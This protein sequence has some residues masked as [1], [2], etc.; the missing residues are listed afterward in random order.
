MDFMVN[1]PTTTK[2]HDVVIIIVD[3]LTKRAHFWPTLTRAATQDTSKLCCS[4]YQRLHGLPSSIVSD[5]DPKFTSQLWAKTMKLPGSEL[6]LSTEFRPSTDGQSEV[7]NKFIVEYLRH[8]HD[9]HQTNW[10][11]YL[12]LGEFAYNSRFHYTTGFAPFVTDLDYLPRLI[13]H[14]FLQLMY[15][16]LLS[17]SSIISKQF[18]LHLKIPWQ[19]LRV[20]GIA[21]TI[22]IILLLLSPQVTRF[23]STLRIWTLFTLVRQANANLLLASSDLF[24]AIEIWREKQPRLP[25]REIETDQ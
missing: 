6:N 8:F 16:G 1:L 22:E 5:C 3:R 23:C 14:Y 15:L 4:F 24:V 20:R 19:Q 25:D 18:W 11:D 13:W 2:I 21:I 9:S 7:T 17:I 12:T 10:E